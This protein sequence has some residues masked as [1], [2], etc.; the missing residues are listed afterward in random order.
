MKIHPTM[1]KKWKLGQ[2]RRWLVN[3][4]HGFFFSGYDC[5]MKRKLLNVLVRPMFAAI[6]VSSLCLLMFRLLQTIIRDTGG[7]GS[8]AAFSFILLFI[9]LQIAIRMH[10]CPR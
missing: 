10:A 8:G 5:C 3:V 6:S 2:T 9:G 4:D 7:S 1:R